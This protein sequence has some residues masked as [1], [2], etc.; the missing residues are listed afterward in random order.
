MTPAS[1]QPGRVIALFL[2]ARHGALPFQV[3]Q[4][5]AVVDSGIEHDINAQRSGSSRQVLLVESADLK[6]LELRAG[7]LREQLTVDLP[8]LMQLPA[9]A[10]LEIGSARLVITKPCEPCTH[11]GETL[12]QEHPEAFRR[13]LAGRRGMLATVAVGGPIAT[14]DTIHVTTAGL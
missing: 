10:T 3:P 1:P 8:A 5:N 6:A 9:G 11:I 14:G 2:K 13:R 12:F 4:V 7:D